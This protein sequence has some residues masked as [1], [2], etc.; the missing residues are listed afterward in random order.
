MAI[1]LNDAEKIFESDSWDTTVD[2]MSD[3]E[4]SDLMSAFQSTNDYARREKNTDNYIYVQ[5]VGEKRLKDLEGKDF[6]TMSASELDGVL[7]LL[8]TFGSSTAEIDSIKHKYEERL[9]VLRAESEN[10]ESSDN[11]GQEQNNIQTPDE[12]PVTNTPAQDSTKTYYEN[13][14]LNS[15]HFI[16]H[17]YLIT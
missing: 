16:H 15:E 17:K 6:S 11:T 9:S 3:K 13:G 12:T 4:L 2:Q 1:T 5:T 14:N 10:S 7:S 8:E